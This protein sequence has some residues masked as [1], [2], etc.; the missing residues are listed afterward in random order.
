MVFLC[1]WPLVFQECI[2][3]WVST[4]DTSANGP[5]G[6][7]FSELHRRREAPRLW[8]SQT[9]GTPPQK[10]KC[11]PWKRLPALCWLCFSWNRASSYFQGSETPQPRCICCP[12][13]QAEQRRGLAPHWEA[14]LPSHLLSAS[15]WKPVVRGPALLPWL[16]PSLPWYMQFVIFAKIKATNCNKINVLSYWP[17]DLP[18]T[19]KP[20]F[21]CSCPVLPG[22]MSGCRC[23]LG[24]RMEKFQQAYHCSSSTNSAEASDPV[25]EAL[26]LRTFQ[27]CRPLFSLLYCAKVLSDVCRERW[28][29]EGRGE[30]KGRKGKRGGG[31]GREGK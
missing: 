7:L 21:A 30:G 8:Q 26:C 25:R 10:M 20:P 14:L 24:R 16:K 12:E 22:T 3:M 31:E 6:S 9:D 13:I 18:L 27:K 2:R 1:I 23:C 15:F 17:S 28:G 19:P 29:E 5:L 4:Q 11:S